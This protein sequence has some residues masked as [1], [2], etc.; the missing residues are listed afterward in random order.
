MS[1]R[2]TDTLDFIG[3]LD[4]YKSD[5]WITFATQQELADCVRACT[6]GKSG[7]V[8]A[9]NTLRHQVAERL[10]TVAQAGVSWA[11]VQIFT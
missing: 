6:D 9:K 5:W 2:P 1:D 8:R 3:I 7:T 4:T 11:K 10:H